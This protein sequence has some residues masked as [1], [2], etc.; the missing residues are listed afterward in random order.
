MLLWRIQN[1]ELPSNLN[2]S[3]FWLLIGTNDI[4]RMWCS[5]EMVVIGIIR[6][7]EEILS[8]KPSAHVVING[9][10]P[11]SF[12]KEGYLAKGGPIKP[13]VWEDINAINS[14]LKMYATYREHVSYF[15]TDVFFKNPDVQPSQLQI[16]KDLMPDLLHPSPMG[17][18]LWGEEIVTML[19][20]LID[21]SED[22]D[23][24]DNDD[25]DEDVRR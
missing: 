24:P 3:V 16:D 23:E 14:E 5:P 17:Y 21:G 8:R 22:D 1:G 9:L 2:P 15:E 7:V 11:R 18:R 20:T 19:D 4:G 25:D 13:S 6:N 12:N 10:L